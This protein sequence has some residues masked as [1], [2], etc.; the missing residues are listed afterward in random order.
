M[1][2]NKSEVL[3]LIQKLDEEKE[4]HNPNSDND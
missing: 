2:N 4:I 3:K 1:N